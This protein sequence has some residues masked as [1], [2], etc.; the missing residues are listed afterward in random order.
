M[1]APANRPAAPPPGGV[2]QGGDVVSAGWAVA[3]V[4]DGQAV[5]L[6]ARVEHA[7]RQRSHQRALLLAEGAIANRLDELAEL[8]GDAGPA[9]AALHQLTHAGLTHAHQPRRLAP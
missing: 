6:P 4:H 7:E 5:A 3:P 2:A 8:R 9:L 1:P